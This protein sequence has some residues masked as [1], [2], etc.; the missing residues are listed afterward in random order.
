MDAHVLAFDFGASSGRA[1]LGNFQD[2]ELVM[3][4]IHRFE[5]IPIEQEGTLYWDSDFLFQQILTGIH[6]AQKLVSIDSIGIDTWGIDFGLL[7]EQGK[8]LSLPVHYRDTRTQGMLE[9]AKKTMLLDK[10]YALTGNQLMEINTLFQLLALRKQQPQKFSQAKKLLMIPD[11]LNYY[12]TGQQVTEVSMAST[13][14]LMDPCKKQWSDKVIQA[15]QLPKHLFPKIVNEGHFL[16]VT[17]IKLGVGNIPVIN[18]CQHDT[19]S[20][21]LSIPSVEPSLFISCGTWSL[22]GTE[23]SEPILTET[24]QSF[25]LTNESGHDDSTCLLKNCTGLWIIQE[26]RRNLAAKGETYSFSELAQAAEESLEPSCLIDTDAPEFGFLGDMQQRIREYA[27]RTGQPIPQSVGA[28]ARCIYESLALK[29]AAVA[30]EIE[31]TTDKFF[32]KINIVGG[33]SQAEL[34]CQLVAD[35]TNKPVLAGPAEATALGN[36]YSQL[37]ALGAVS[38]VPSVREK[39]ALSDEIRK[40][41]PNLGNYLEKIS[42]YNKIIKA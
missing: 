1:V 42:F 23:L 34:L 37:I 2:G 19:A 32:S 3:Q 26:F 6:L 20:A 38:N 24:A 36:I 17:Q 29:Y 8:L 12:L 11:L 13:T 16:G 21:V 4:E 9:E 7:N 35:Y 10:L 27:A 18:V 28:I 25:N 41:K 40:Y 30:K 15:F 31:Q 39:L 33:G 14:Q 5:N 22:I